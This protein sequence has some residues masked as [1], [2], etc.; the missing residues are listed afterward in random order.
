MDKNYLDL[1]IRRIPHFPKQGIL[2]YDITTLFE[3]AE[4]FRQV[5]NELC[6]QHEQEKIDKVVGIDARG[7]LIASAMAY[8]LGAG[9]SIVRKQGRLPH[10][11]KKASYEKEYGPDII[12]MHEDTIKPGEKVIIV[13]DLLATGG[14]MLAAADL[15]KQLGGVILGID[16][17][18][19]LA[20]LPGLKKLKEQGYKVNHLIDFDSEAVN[21]S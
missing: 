2:F 11:T 9:I 1:K 15:V 16:F 12:E 4:A 19:N 6:R 8:K 17:V 7:F 20:F 18:I 13:D 14:T 5:I 21:G 10:K 3:D